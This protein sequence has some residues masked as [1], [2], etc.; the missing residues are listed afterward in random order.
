MIKNDVRRRH[1]QLMLT[2]GLIGLSV[3]MPSVAAA[4]DA[5]I[6]ADEVAEEEVEDIVVTG[7]RIQRP[8]A[9]TATPVVSVTAENIVQSGINNVSELLAQ[10]PALFNSE[11]NFDA[12]G[13]QARTGAAGVNLLN[14]RNLGAN[15][16]LVLVDGR[17]HIA[18]VSGEAAVDTNTIPVSLI[19]RVDILTG[20]VSSVYGADGV[21]GVVNFIMRR[22]FEGIDIRAQNGVSD[23]GDAESR[24]FSAT[25][26]KNFADD[27][28]NFTLN[29]EYRD[30][31][32]VGYG[33]RPNGRFEADTLVRNPD[34]FLADGTDDPNKPDF[35]FLNRIGYSDSA[36]GGAIIIRQT[37]DGD[38]PPDFL[39][40]GLPYDRGI[41]L[42]QSG[43]LAQGGDNTPINDYQGDLQA[44]TEHHSFNAFF[45]YQLTP[46]IRFFAEGKYVK[47]E[48]FTIAQPSFDFFTYISEDN[49]LIP[50]NIRA[51][52]LDQFGGLLFNRDNFDFGTRDE[53]FER[54]LYRTVIGFDGN[55]SDNV[56]F[57][58]SYV[59][60]RNDTT[61]ISTNQRI[62]DRYFAALDVVDVGQ[63]RTGV[64]NGVF[65]CRVNVDGGA[66]A[67]AGNGNY[68]EAPQTFTPG[69]CVP[70]NIFGEGVASQAALDFILTD[71]ENEYR[72]EQHV[73][74]AFISG[75][76]GKFFELPGG[77]INF[78]FGG[79][80]RKESSNFRPD[81][82]STQVTDFDPDSGVLADLALLA[83][84]RGSFDVWEV[85]GEIN[86]P[87]LAD[88]PFFE[89][90]EFTVA[91]R[92][93]DYS[94]VGTTEAWSVNGQWA[95][96]RDI[97]FRGGYSESVRAPN[98][99]EL[100]APRSGTFAFIND[101]CGPENL[102]QGT[103][104]RAANCRALIEGLGVD[105]DTFDPAS[106]I[107]ASASRE[108]IFS[109]NRNLTE[110]G[111]TTWT[112]GVIL[113][114][115]FVPGLTVT[116]DWYD[117]RLT[118]AVRTATLNETAQF[119]VDSATLDN[120]FCDLIERSTSTG[121]VS[122]YELS[123]QNVAFI[124]T[125]GA[126]VTVNYAFE[127]GDGKLGRFNLRGTVGYLDKLLVLPANGGIVDDNQGENGSPEWVGTADITWSLDN[128]TLNY[129][130][131]YVGDQLRFER[132]QIAGDPD[133]AAPE[134]LVINDRFIHDLRAE[135]TTDNEQASFF[136]GVNNFTN[137]LPI[138][139]IASQ[140]G[141]GWLGRYFYA[142][143]R[144]NTD[145]LGF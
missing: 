31:A 46:D 114:P 102:N 112:A 98:I 141:V 40:S 8:E 9:A 133:I 37:P 66:L 73:A 129:G 139:G 41:F 92:Y 71:T 115:S 119:C 64:A 14:L 51:A 13:S 145:Q 106:D 88:R 65:D 131:Q 77:A 74:N 44:G 63:F 56:K 120:V 22:D 117:I 123:P 113:Q 89:V 105:F 53:N 26:G 4:Q 100:F 2:A 138:R 140:S 7:T 110:E 1:A 69:Q 11:T 116:G 99:T 20:G 57:E 134:F 95:P 50:A 94:T 19:E 59:Y 24:F 3:G 45:N 83:P 30:D 96:I 91:G 16:T 124:E 125:A 75:D 43:F 61:Y 62:E 86:V 101:P 109:G 85:F 42:P 49:P 68:G 12:A 38:L 35:V 137:E 33:D 6:T 107:N 18:G 79:E 28:G 60:G 132:D 143:L 135:F 29:Y 10:S 127:P 17:R 108:G 126:D 54:D 58:A 121:F 34:G 103:S 142:G 122:N 136:L 36:P 90:L 78:A 70:L 81:A 67:D 39:G 97:R 21:S 27:R 55:V 23:F 93:S 47:S 111:A 76:F 72:I 5:V 15:R 80:Y 104:F 84:E 130:V 52:G 87:I 128:V 82:I 32:R 144:I 118:N 48:N 25:I